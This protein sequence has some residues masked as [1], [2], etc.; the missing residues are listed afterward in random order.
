MTYEQ[1]LKK[2]RERLISDMKDIEREQI[3]LSSKHEAYSRC[4]ELIESLM[5]TVEQQSEV[6]K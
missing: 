3:R 6:Q 5:L 4:V 2:L 1:A